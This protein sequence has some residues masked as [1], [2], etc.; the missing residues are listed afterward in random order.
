MRPPSSTGA[1]TLVALV[2]P[3]LLSEPQ[4]EPLNEPLSDTAAVGTAANGN[5]EVRATQVKRLGDEERQAT[6]ASSDNPSWS[7]QRRGKGSAEAGGYS[8][9]IGSWP[10]TPS[11]VTGAAADDIRKII[12]CDCPPS[13]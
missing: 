3:E 4:S 9:N 2:R 10:A 1:T 11:A 5:T 7:S 12:G 8:A 13:A 6:L